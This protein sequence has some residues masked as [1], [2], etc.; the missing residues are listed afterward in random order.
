MT[1]SARPEIAPG[2]SSGPSHA[3]TVRVT[4]NV[5]TH[6]T[7]V[8]DVQIDTLE[9]ARQY[10]EQHGFGDFELQSGSRVHEQLVDVVSCEVV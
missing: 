8:V 5:T 6:E 1:R 4:C 7:I 2:K 3:A 9:E 10:V